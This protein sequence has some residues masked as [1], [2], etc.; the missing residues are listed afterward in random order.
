MWIIA[1]PEVQET[2]LPA[3]KRW[4]RPGSIFSIGRSQLNDLSIE[5]AKSVSKQ[6]AEIRVGTVPEGAS[7]DIAHRTELVVCDLN[8]KF[9]TFVTL[10][11]LEAESVQVQE[12]FTVLSTEVLIRVGKVKFELKIYWRPIV[13]TLSNVKTRDVQ[14]DC[15]KLDIKYSKEFVSST[16]HVVTKKY[17]TP[18]TLQGLAGQKW[19]VGLPYIRAMADASDELAKNIDN[20]PDPGLLSYLPEDAFNQ[21]FGHAAFLPKAGREHTFLELEFVIFDS[22]QYQSL[23]GAIHAGGGS[24]TEYNQEFDKQSISAF[25][26]TLTKPVVVLPLEGFMLKLFEELLPI[27]KCASLTQ[28][29]FINVFMSDGLHEIYRAEK[30]KPLPVSMFAAAVEKEKEPI[31]SISQQV[32]PDTLQTQPVSAVEQPSSRRIGSRSVRALATFEDD[33]FG[34]GSLPAPTQRTNNIYSS[35]NR[36]EIPAASQKLAESYDDDLFGSS[37]APPPTNYSQRSATLPGHSVARDLQ[38]SSPDQTKRKRSSSPFSEGERLPKTTKK[39]RTL[40]TVDAEEVEDEFEAAPAAAALAKRMSQVAPKASGLLK[41]T[42]PDPGP[43]EDTAKRKRQKQV[44]ITEEQIQETL[45]AN[46]QRVERET[47][48]QEDEDEIPENDQLRN[49]GTVEYFSFDLPEPSRAAARST[50]QEKSDRWDPKWNGRKNFKA[51]RRATKGRAS[52]QTKRPAIMIRLV[53]AKVSDRGL[54]DHQWLETATTR[55]NDAI[56]RSRNTERTTNAEFDPI[57]TRAADGSRS[58]T[59]GVPRSRSQ[60]RRPEDVATAQLNSQKSIRASSQSARSARTSTRTRQQTLF[61]D[62]AS[63]SDDD[64]LKFRL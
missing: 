25:L 50:G 21:E 45:K 2:N 13:L 57:H 31:V 55:N 43:L 5:S 48:A 9:H 27:I 38:M 18:K 63:D 8:S 19:I 17:N 42:V 23:N 41:R 47:Q 54:M 35:Q 51:F 26:S 36:K 4:L 30:M 64:P 7:A 10:A 40:V 28:G 46:K 60:S 58:Q 1:I 52:V 59:D 15:E 49:L 11:D 29:E 22:H 14:Q 32:A 3:H 39:Q 34:G 62:D 56:S 33:L 44:E 20:M 61:V 24:V 12:Q 6:H 37:I 16:T 53:E